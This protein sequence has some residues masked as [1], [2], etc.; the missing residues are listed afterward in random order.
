M[1]LADGSERL[2][3]TG[4]DSDIS[5]ALIIGG[6]AMDLGMATMRSFTPLNL[7]K[8]LTNNGLEGYQMNILKTHRIGIVVCFV[9]TLSGCQS[10][11]NMWFGEK[12]SRVA[13]APSLPEST[14]SIAPKRT[15]QSE[16]VAASDPISSVCPG[17]LR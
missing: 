16:L 3:T 5:V 10:A 15:A 9:T 1:K 12:S 6:D 17:S 14:E 7:P 4:T 13:S 2:E 8:R 11:R